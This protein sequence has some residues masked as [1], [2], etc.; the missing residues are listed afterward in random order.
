MLKIMRLFLLSIVITVAMASVATVRAEGHDQARQMADQGKILPLQSITKRLRHSVEGR[1]LEAEL[2]GEDDHYV[3]ELE[4]LSPDG[5]IQKLYY[6]AATG[7][8][9]PGYKEHE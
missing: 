8:P 5:S 2:E 9:V 7:E 6:D 1:V 3:Y 4:L